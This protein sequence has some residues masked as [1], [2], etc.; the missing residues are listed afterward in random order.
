MHSRILHYVCV[1]VCFYK[2]HLGIK[3]SGSFPRQPW[4]LCFIILGLLSGAAEMPRFQTQL[5][6]Q[7]RALSA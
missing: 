1:F 2:C 6:E 5:S 7:L 4:L 3:S